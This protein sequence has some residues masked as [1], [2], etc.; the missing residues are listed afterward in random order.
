MR[1]ESIKEKVKAIRQNYRK[2]VTGRRSSRELVM[3]S[4]TH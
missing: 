3:I 2:A 1:Y 4:R